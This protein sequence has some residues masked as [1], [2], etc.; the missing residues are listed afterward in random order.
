MAKTAM[1]A[2]VYYLANALLGRD[3]W[4][5]IMWEIHGIK[6][7]GDHKKAN[8]LRATFREGASSG[9]QDGGPMGTNDRGA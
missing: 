8:S 5:G 1:T 7:R 6:K 9:K 3:S 2:L 4:A